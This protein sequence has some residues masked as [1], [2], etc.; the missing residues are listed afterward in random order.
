MSL[1]SLSKC[2]FTLSKLRF[3]SFA[4][5]KSALVIQLLKEWMVSAKL[6]GHHH[7]YIIKDL[8]IGTTTISCQKGIDT[9]L[10]K[11]TLPK[12]CVNFRQSSAAVAMTR[13]MADGTYKAYFPFAISTE[14]SLMRCYHENYWMKCSKDFIIFREWRTI[15]FVS[16]RILK[17]SI[18]ADDEPPV[19][20]RRRN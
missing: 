10:D 9:M 13:E 17:K 8:Q 6:V 20:R 12:D 2:S 15:V 18:F 7:F 4:S 5:L 16:V 3:S 1:R 11:N 19:S 14:A